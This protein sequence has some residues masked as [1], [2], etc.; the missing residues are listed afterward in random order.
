MEKFLVLMI[1]CCTPT[2]AV[3]LLGALFFPLPGVFLV[4]LLVFCFT[5]DWLGSI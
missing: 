1:F 5:L 2:T 3:F 4:S